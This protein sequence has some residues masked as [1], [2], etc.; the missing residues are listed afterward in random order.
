MDFF[1]LFSSRATARSSK[2]HQS[3]SLLRK[4]SFWKFNNP[5][6]I[7]LLLCQAQLVVCRWVL[8]GVGVNLIISLPPISPLQTTTGY[9]YCIPAWDAGEEGL[10]W[11]GGFH[12][13]T[14]AQEPVSLSVTE[15]E[16]PDA[17][18]IESCYGFWFFF[19]SPPF[20]SFSHQRPMGVE[21]LNRSCILSGSGQ[22]FPLTDSFC[23]DHI[24]PPEKPA[25]WDPNNPRLL[26]KH[27]CTPKTCTFVPQLL[28]MHLNWSIATP[29]HSMPW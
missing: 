21:P 2:S 26:P 16:L 24:V 23:W 28:K 6:S 5:F 22:P 19:F 10:E 14:E 29:L 8:L 9:S 3:H 15:S 13:R 11:E 20:W 25:G 7:K 4:T 18:F 1:L 12:S 27:S 17:G